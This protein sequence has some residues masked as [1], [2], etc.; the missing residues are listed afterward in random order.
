MLPLLHVCQNYCSTRNAYCNC[1]RA[2]TTKNNGTRSLY[3]PNYTP[4]ANL[5]TPNSNDII[6]KLAKSFVKLSL[7]ELAEFYRAVDNPRLLEH[8]KS[9]SQKNT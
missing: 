5:D 6:S 9:S 8:L 3:A 4:L 2:F 7:V 1:R